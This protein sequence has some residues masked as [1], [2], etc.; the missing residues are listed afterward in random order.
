MIR[1]AAVVATGFVLI[2][3]VSAQDKKGATDRDRKDAPKVFYLVPLVARPGEEQ[4]LVLRGRNL[5]TVTEVKAEG[6]TAKLLG[7]KKAPPGKDQG[8]NKAGDTE[9]EVELELPEGAKPG[10]VKLVAVGP[11]GESEPY[12]LLVRDGT[13]A[14]AEKEPNDGFDTAQVVPFPCAVEGVVGKDKDADVYRFDGKKGDKVTVEVQA[15]RWGSP[16]DALVTVYD[17][18]RRTVAAA[19]DSAGSPDPVL[20]LTLPRDGPYFVTLIDAHD[21]GG[22]G[23]GYRLVIRTGG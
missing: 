13:P 16:L 14:A 11:K 3:S 21:A 8:A 7:K 10:S 12:T 23:F 17:A 19:D 5:D 20:T 9:A 18:D 15:A 4:K 6:A 2:T 22:Q 1:V